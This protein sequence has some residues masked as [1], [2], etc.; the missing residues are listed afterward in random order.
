VRALKLRVATIGAGYF[1]RFHHNAWKW[2]E[3]VELVAVVDRE[4]GKAEAFAVDFGIPFVFDDVEEMLATVQ[5]DIVDIVAPPPAHLPTIRAA[6][7][8]GVHAICQKP[9]CQSLEEA[10]VAVAEIA[11]AGIT[12]AVHENFRFQPWHQEAKRIIDSG[13]LGEIYQVTFRLRPGD[14]Q[15]DNAY[16]DRQPYFRTMARLLVHET[17]IHHIDLFRYLLGEPAAVYADLRRVNPVIA[18][19]DAGLV[20]M[21]MQSG[22]RAVFDGNRCSDHI[23]GNRRLTMGEMQI[24]GSAGVLR[25]DGDGRLF[26]RTHGENT[27]SPHEFDWRNIDFGGDCVYRTQ[28]A[29]VD[30]LKAGEVPANRADHYLANLHI[31]EAIYLSHAEG[32]RIVL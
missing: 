8:H 32:R 1:S 21:S 31:E 25:L 7:R 11:A 14:G 9:F 13:T 20:V 5:P 18:G 24:E 2:M 17:A 27:E 29:F 26:R 6:A 4:R 12:V 10:D 19:E 22:A 15:G 23:A 30:A 3:D 16:L 28:R